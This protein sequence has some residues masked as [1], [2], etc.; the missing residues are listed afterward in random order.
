[1]VESGKTTVYELKVGMTC[2]GCSGAVERIL[3][4]KSEIKEV[5]CDIPS[6]QVIVK[7]E[8]G[9]DI[10]EMLRKWVS[11]F[12]SSFMR[13]LYS[14]SLRVSQLSLSTRHMNEHRI[15]H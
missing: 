14:L 12:E 10:V 3:G 9:L 8:D 15:S 4:K 2:E 7:G 6:G 5:K 1:M 13:Y 11:L